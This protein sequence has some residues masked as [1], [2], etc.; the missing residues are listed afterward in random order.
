MLERTSVCYKILPSREILL[1][2]KLTNL[3]KISHYYIESTM[4]HCGLRRDIKVM[5]WSDILASS[6]GQT[7]DKTKFYGIYK[8]T[9]F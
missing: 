5:D 8:T 4:E 2:D 9:I 1:A 6:W 3:V 7:R